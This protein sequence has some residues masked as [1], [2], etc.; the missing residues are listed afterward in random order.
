MATQGRP[1]TPEFQR[2][3]VLLQDY[4]D[5][6]KDDLREQGCPSA[7]RTAHALGVGIATVKRVMAAYHRNPE[8][9]D[10]SEPIPRGRPPWVLADALQPITRNDVC[11]ANQE[12]SH[13]T[14]E[15]F[16]AHLKQAGCE[17]HFSVRTLGRALDRWGFTF[18]KGT[19]SHHLK[20]KEHVVAAR[21]RYLRA[22]RANRQGDDVIRPEVYWDA[23]YVNKNHS[24]DVIWYS[25]EDGPGVQKPR[26]KGERLLIMHAMPT[27]GWRPG[28]QLTFKSTRKTG[29]YHGQMHHDLFV[30]WFTEQLLP[31][32]PAH[33]LI[34]MDNAPYHNALSRHAA[35]TA[36]CNTE[37]IRSWLHQNGIPIRD[38]CLKAE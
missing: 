29:D 11:Q 16:A 3:I 2:A 22:Q 18:G 8:V 23:S 24:N 34:I 27:R 28:A 15:M 37:D 38:A 36:T 7:E 33:S 32:M 9:L 19:R 10:R 1:L 6:T 12:C 25:E 4:F 21:Q 13:L 14:L 31:N 35:P 30:T 5:R 17:A 26:G 20:E